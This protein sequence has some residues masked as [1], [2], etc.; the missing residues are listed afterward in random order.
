M[1][2]GSKI[3]AKLLSSLVLDKKSKEVLSGFVKLLEKN[4]ELKRIN[5]IISLAEKEILKKTGSKKITI[6]VAR[7]LDLGD[8][9]KVFRKNG[10]I[11]KEKIS[12]EL[13]AG[14]KIIANDEKQLDYSLKS[15]LD[16]V[17]NVF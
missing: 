12:P 13:L 14:V 16:K 5:E 1:K 9:L 2:Y 3:Y 11:V 10:N 6:Q 7:S 15:K 8:F 17:F 4:G